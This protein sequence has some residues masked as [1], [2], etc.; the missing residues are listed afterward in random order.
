M[1]KTINVAMLF[2]VTIMKGKECNDFKLKK[3]GK[4]FN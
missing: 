3:A 1:M 4:K 2:S